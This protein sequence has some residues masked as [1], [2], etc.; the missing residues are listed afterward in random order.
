M[1]KKEDSSSK[2]ML[3]SFGRIIRAGV[4]GFFRN[5]GLTFATIFVMFMVVFLVTLLFLFNAASNVL[6]ADIQEKVDISVYF[7]EDALVDDILEVKIAVANIPEV[8]EV[9]YV[10]KEKALEGFIERHNDDPVLM[11]SLTEVGRNPFLASLNIRAWQASQ[12][13]QVVN[14]LETSAFMGLINK[15]DYYQRAGVIEK[16]FAVTSSINKGM[17]FFGIFLGLVAFLI[18]FSTIRLAIMNNKEEI[19][20]MKLVGASNWFVR[21]PFLVQGVTAGVLA[22]L[23]SLLFTFILSYGL[24]AP[25]KVLAPQISMFSLFISNFWLILFVQLVVGIGLGA[26]SSFFAVK[27][28]LKV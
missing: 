12:Y 15:I 5:S 9:E 18:A 19:S 8:K 6:I 3:T 23:L 22:I 7:E 14:F 28:C 1:I 4:K 20:V 10:S 25:I 26:L 24:N 27:K 17:I 21:G 11:E 13:S 16:V 2:N